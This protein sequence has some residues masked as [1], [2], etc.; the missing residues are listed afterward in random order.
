[1]SE[2]QIMADILNR[3]INAGAWGT[4]HENIDRIRNWVSNQLKK[5]GKRVTKAINRLNSERFVGTKNNGQSIYANPR[6][7]HEISDF[8]EKHYVDDWNKF[9]KK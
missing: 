2:E 3:L 9:P 6:K 1:M 4:G 7:R 5:N 8:I